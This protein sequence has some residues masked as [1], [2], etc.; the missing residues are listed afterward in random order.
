MKRVWKGIDVIATGQR[1]RFLQQKKGL[2]NHVLAEMLGVSVQALYKWKRG[3]T[4]PDLV[5]A[6]HLARILGV[7][8][9]EIFLLAEEQ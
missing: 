9:E 7:S 4:L 8:V 1:I 3:E 5:H 6:L 2:A